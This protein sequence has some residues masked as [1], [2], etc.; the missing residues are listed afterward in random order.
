[1]GTFLAL[2]TAVVFGWDDRKV[3]PQPKLA[4][5]EVFLVQNTGLVY[6]DSIGREIERIKPY[7]TNG[8]ISPDG[9][10]LACVQCVQFEQN[11]SRS[12]LA[13]HSRSPQ[14]GTTTVPLKF[15]EDGA[16]STLV[17]S[18]DSRRLLI[19]ENR[20]GVGNVTEYAN[21][22]YELSTKKLT[23]ITLP[24]SHWVSGWSADSK[25]FL[26]TVRV[27]SS[28]RIAW[29]S[30]DG[31]GK[32]EFLTPK[33]EN[34]FGPRLSPDGEMVLFQAGP[35]VH[36]GPRASE[37]LYVM[38]LTTKKR[39]TIDQPG[40]AY[41]YC[42][43]RDGSKIAY[44]WQ[45]PMKNPGDV[46]ERETFLITCD[47]DGSN[48]RTVTSRKYKPVRPDAGVVYFFWVFDWR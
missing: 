38:E 47:W 22:I 1:M 15:D 39:V 19:A 40:H 46:A 11:P 42:W 6:L 21:R 10:W 34:A 2:L 27:E 4:A 5:A 7:A 31:K 3:A 14:G 13:I 24:H 35:Q 18:P 30:A 17:W 20:A 41:G 23:E 44:T 8:A 33:G 32:T 25:K 37:R 16:G 36:E 26:T 43:S 12:Y 48:R 29:L 45:R 9:R 28:I